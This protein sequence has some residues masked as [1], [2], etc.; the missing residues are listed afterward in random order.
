MKEEEKVCLVEI[1]DGECSLDAVVV[2]SDVRAGD[3][4]GVKNEL[5]KRTIGPLRYKLFDCGARAEIKGNKR[6]R[7]A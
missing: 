1:V 3:H 5:I 6:D 4:S 7:I 2:E